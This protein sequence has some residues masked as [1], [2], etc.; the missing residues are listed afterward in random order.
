[1][2]PETMHADRQA[3]RREIHLI[4]R[5]SHPENSSPKIIQKIQG[6]ESRIKGSA[7]IRRWRAEHRPIP[8]YLEKLPIIAKKEEIVRAI[9]NNQTII[10]SGE[11]GSG[12]T[13]QLPKFCLEAGRGLDGMI[14]CT[15]P[16]R[17]AAVTVAH[18][19]ADEFS[20]TPGGVV[21]YKIRFQDHVSRE[22]S[23]IKLMTD[24]ILLAEAQGDKYLNE[25]DTLIIDEAH[26]RSINI[27]FILGMLKRILNVRRELKLIVTSATIDT[28][29]FSRAFDHAPIIE[30]S[31][32]MYP[33]EVQYARSSDDESSD[34]TTYV[35]HAVDAVSRI[36]I[37]SGSGD[38]LVFM[39][40]EQDIRETCEMLEGRKFKHV[41][42]LPLFARLS[43]SDQMKV[44]SPV[45]GRKII[46]ATNVAET[47]IT[48]PGIRYVVDTGLA[49]ILRYD[50][51]TRTT[52]LPILPVSRS[53][54]DQRKG[55]CGRIENG[56]CIRLFSKEDY[57][58]RPL[59]TLPEIL[60]ANLSEVILRMIGLGLGDIKNFPF[61]DPPPSRQIKDGFDM[62]FEL[63]AIQPG[64]GEKQEKE[65]FFLTPKGRV[66]ARIPLDPRLSRMLIEASQNDCLDA[67]AVIVSAL[68]I[69]DPKERP[70]DSIQAAQEA[71]SRFKDP[72]SD[73]I[74]LYN[75]WK[76]CFGEPGSG[77]ITRARDLKKFCKANFMSF[78]RMRE[79]QD[80]HEQIVDIL[81]ESGMYAAS[82]KDGAVGAAP[83]GC[84]ST[85]DNGI[86]SSQYTSIHKSILSGFLS[87]IAVKKEKNIYTAAKQREV[88]LFP[89]SGLFNKGGAWIVSAEIVETS[90]LYARL[91]ASIDSSWLEPV[92]RLQCKYSYSNP[93]WEKKREA[94]VADEQVSLYG[95][96]IVAGRPV[97]FGPLQ[98]EEATG[99][100]IQS[101]L[102][103]GDVKTVLPFM[104]HNWSLIEG[105]HDM[106]NRV[107]RRDFLVSESAML[108]FYRSKLNGVWDMAGLKKKIKA[109]GS[110]RF[111][112]MAQS[113]LLT[114]PPDESQLALYPDK[115]SIG[116]KSYSCTYYFEPGQEKDGVTV[117]L[118]ASVVASVPADAPDWL[119]PGLLEEKITLLIR[120]LPKGFR[121][122][123]VP[124]TD[125]VAAI[126]REMPKYTGSL[127]SSL[128]R[129]IYGR[130][131]VDIP[132]SAWRE[133]SLPDYLKMRISLIGADGREVCAGR[134][135]NM[136]RQ[137]YVPE[138]D[139]DGLEEERRKWERTGLTQWDFPDLPE[140]I[141][142]TGKNG[143][144]FPVFPALKKEKDAAGL[145]L[146]T[147]HGAAIQ[148]HRQGVAQLYSLYFAKDLRF[149]KKNLVL[150]TDM[151]KAAAY[152]GGKK[153]FETRLFDRVMEDLFARPIRTKDDFLSHAG[154][155]VNRIIPA[156][157]QVMENAL[158]VVKAYCE[159]RTRIYAL[160][161]ANASDPVIGEF[162][163]EIR[164]SLSRII[165]E[166]FMELYSLDRISTLGRYIKGLA[167]RAERGIHDM[168]KD[169][170]KAAKIA[171]FINDLSELVAQLNASASSEK[172]EALESLVWMV[173]EYKVSLFAQELKTAFPVSP[174]KIEDKIREI[175]RMV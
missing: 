139:L 11:T 147:D 39:P 29:K 91:A 131:K 42:V 5:R 166:N 30:V 23:F 113:D 15:Q 49:R 124:I 81:E 33:V 25:Y 58:A 70:E 51:R 171:P 74:S 118:P 104:T 86:F 32:R 134:D 84:P 3:I 7:G 34:D 127:A 144:L 123:L 45:A 128:S 90:R 17:I 159:G 65:K 99:I 148:S 155:C 173:E 116:R 125:T 66:M 142:I 80:I 109:E 71:H 89:G 87:N 48:V 105:I 88:M 92:G 37:S 55:R 100:F 79:W 93:R 140:S 135:K 136:L 122:Q 94:V 18:R 22:R 14:G 130:F 172:R 52:A 21:G 53:S 60:R 2:L 54:A 75:I 141:M 138:K 13:T 165:P 168:D 111:L 162:L 36:V 63:G 4:R 152:F 20:E 73:F 77:K 163:K 120:G 175:R 150:P 44:F 1:M 137:A 43:A 76:S 67:A 69:P 59:Y 167:L 26:E 19:I 82:S 121:K 10:V 85:D 61:I 97:P 101:A 95:L 41:T 40:T 174:K 98:P 156:G 102:I 143:G 126:M 107:R 132:A 83:S 12:K 145:R 27:D 47:S 46:V 157:K 24:G 114:A 28:E 149:L 158:P 110:D 35:E 161:K 38:I 57:D 68:T 62:L 8:L 103:D 115:L 106:E 129:F 146:F 170:K 78:K 72:A 16:R 50:P 169:R 133:D 56:I 151:E 96:V 108:E 31:G 9:Q 64:A 153:I 117:N 112:R 119:V 160:E 6:L 154:E 164:E